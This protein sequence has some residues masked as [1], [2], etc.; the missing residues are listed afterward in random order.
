MAPKISVNPLV[1]SISKT[2]YIIQ[3]KK[4]DRVTSVLNYFTPPDLV[5]WYCKEGK[6]AKKKSKTAKS[7]GTRVHNLIKEDW[8]KGRYRI[9]DYDSPAILNCLE[10]YKNWR[11]IE[12]PNIISMEQTVW[13]DEL[14]VAGTYDIQ[15]HNSF[16]RLID[17]KTSDSIKDSYWI[18]LAMYIYLAGL[19]SL[20][21][22]AVLRLDKL[23]ADYQYVIKNYNEYYVKLFKGLLNYYRYCQ[24]PEI[25][26]IEDIEMLQNPYERSFI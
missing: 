4:F 10:A 25:R 3:D 20:T 26:D 15:T 19:P 2:S 12:K 24:K 13:S 23:T 17:I 8:E 7:I 1:S 5:N 11:S 18:Q 22:M 21:S 6:Q 14:G 16:Y 9:T